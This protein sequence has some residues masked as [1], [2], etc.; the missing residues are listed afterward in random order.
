MTM[1]DYIQLSIFIVMTI[2]LVAILWQSVIQNRLLKSQILKDR[3]EMYWKTY[4]PI[5]RE[6]VE[7]LK[8]YPKDYMNSQ[9]YE[10]EYKN[11][12]TAIRRYIG[13]SKLYEYLAFT[14]TLK[15]LKIPDPLGP[16]WLEIWTRELV[17]VKEFCDVHEHYR[18][19]YPPF[20]KL[21]DEFISGV[22]KK[23]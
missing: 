7:E 4:E 2:T 15:Q 17:N 23:N 18:N 11:D 20:E 21:I 5:S 6:E 1:A 22:S 9:K 3:F 14:Y 16:S 8:I 12:D 13:M 19:Y 10:K